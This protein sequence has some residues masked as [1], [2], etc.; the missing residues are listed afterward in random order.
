[1]ADADRLLPD[2]ISLRREIHRTPELGL[3]LPR[4]QELVL[5]ALDGLAFTPTTGNTVSSVVADMGIADGP[6]VLLRG[7]MD[8]LPM[9]E[10]TG[11]EFASAID[12]CMLACGHAAHT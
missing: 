1:M 6:V 12:G 10:D 11:L 8:A 5:D 4:T 3:T 9:P 2:A 7:D